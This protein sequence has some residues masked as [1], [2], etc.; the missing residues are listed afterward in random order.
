MSNKFKILVAIGLILGLSVS[1]ISYYYLKQMI[2]QKTETV[3]IVVP[4]NN[5]E[6]YSTITTESLTQIA[7]SPQLVDQYTVKTSSELIGKVALQTLYAKRLIDSRAI[8]DQGEDLGQ[9]QVV[10]IYCDTARSAGVGDGDTVDV[11]WSPTSRQSAQAALS[12]SHRIALN[13]R[14]LKVCDE[15]GNSIKEQTVIK[16]GIASVAKPPESK[17]LIYLLAQPAEV[18]YIVSGSN[19]PSLTLVKKA[20]PTAESPADETGE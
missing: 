10:G 18:Q 1:G 15:Y 13:A 12:P 3:I 5:I 17:Y 4:K 19:S 20:S 16:Q 6:A 8:A 2:H 14:V 7:V 11:Y 9:S